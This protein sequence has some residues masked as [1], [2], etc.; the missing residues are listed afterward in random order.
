MDLLVAAVEERDQSLSLLGYDAPRYVVIHE[1][2]RECI[3]NGLLPDGSF[4]PPLRALASALDCSRPTLTRAIDMLKSEGYLASR[5]GQGIRVQSTDNATFPSHEANDLLAQSISSR[6]K[7]FA[8]STGRMHLPSGSS[9]AFRPGTPPL[10]L[11]PVERW[12]KITNDYWKSIKFSE[13]AYSPSSGMNRL[14]ENL[15]RYLAVARGVRCHP[16]QLIITSGS[17]QSIYQ[18]ATA[19]VD[20]GD[21]VYVEGST[22]PNVLSV[23][24]G[25]QAHLHTLDA[26]N[27]QWVFPEALRSAKLVH[28]AP[29][30]SYPMG[31]SMSLEKRKELLALL[32][33]SGTIV[34]ENDYE[35]EFNPHARSLPSLFELDGGQRTI[36]LGTFNR[37]LHPSIRIG[38]MV[39]PPFLL[40]TME[41]LALHSHRFVP[42]SL[43]WV[44]KKF[45]EKTYLH[46]QLEKA[47]AA[48]T[49]RREV[50]SQQWH[51]YAGVLQPGVWELVL[52][53][54]LGLSVVIRHRYA[55]SDASLVKAVLEHG[56]ITNRLSLCYLNDPSPQG[57]ILGFSCIHERL[58]P[59]KVKTLIEALLSWEQKQSH[60]KLATCLD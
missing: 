52:P 40:P 3:V 45:L 36:Y 50:L 54:N 12:R 11:F 49:V 41:S 28:L 22:F 44:M 37:L 20:P 14:K 60:P 24:T 13:L 9:L 17:L 25:M 46:E 27:G 51:R 34:L 23:L 43:Q 15:A 21:H 18:S 16:S 2:V 4:L 26:Q 42:P 35:R 8:G 32:A 57:L 47:A 19:L 55:T 56:M 38:F 39:V 7:S 48:L 29:S 59:A 33:H 53:E 5:I 58:L 1:A 10:D 31:T 30:A 6:G